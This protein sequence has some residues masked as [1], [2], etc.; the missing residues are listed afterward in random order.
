MNA[1]GLSFGITVNALVQPSNVYPDRSGRTN[2]TL[3]DYARP[4]RA[5]LAQPGGSPSSS[6]TAHRNRAVPPGRRLTGPWSRQARCELAAT[7]G[8]SRPA[9]G[10]TIAR[11]KPRLREDLSF[12]P[13]RLAAKSTLA[14]IRPNETV[15]RAWRRRPSAPIR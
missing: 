6:M 8:T 1:S 7:I 9:E 14:S 3:E 12:D 15:P 13:S 4:A 11:L 10:D 2:A 5:V